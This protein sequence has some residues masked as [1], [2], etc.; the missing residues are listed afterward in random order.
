MG[1]DSDSQ[2]YA[3]NTQ[4]EEPADVNFNVGGQTLMGTEPKEGKKSNEEEDNSRLKKISYRR[5]QA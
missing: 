3:G 4:A 2:G 5:I 1:S